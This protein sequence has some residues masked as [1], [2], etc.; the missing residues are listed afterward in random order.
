MYNNLDHM[1]NTAI[2]VTLRTSYILTILTWHLGQMID[3]L[4]MHEIISKQC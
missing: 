2:H 3:M 1:T 4:R